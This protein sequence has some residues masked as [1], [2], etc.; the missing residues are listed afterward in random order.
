MLNSIVILVEKFLIMAEYIFG[1]MLDYG[2]LLIFI[3]LLLIANSMVNYF[4][5]IFETSP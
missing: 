5:D 3:G 2:F 1:F 4:T